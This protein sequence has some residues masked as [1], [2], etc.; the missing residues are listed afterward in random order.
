MKR[1]LTAMIAALLMVGLIASTAF[2]ATPS[3]LRIEL[4]NVVDPVNYGV[5]TA[6]VTG[7]ASVTLVVGITTGNWGSY[8]AVY[9]NAKAP[10]G[11]PLSKV[12]FGF[13]STGPSI[14]G[15]AP[16]LSIPIDT[17][18]DSGWDIFAFLD[19]ANCGSGL[20]STTIA[21]CPVFTSLGNYAN[22]DALV[23]ANSTW[24]MASDTMPFAIADQPGTYAL[25][26]ID[27]N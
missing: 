23:L 22:W 18:G 3:R 9:V 26:N 6:T 2:A 14:A 7:A 13:A 4:G 21:T 27:L 19:V 24:K 16:R 1:T 10:Y 5:A 11:K 20:V 17:N 8:A 12:D 15:G 25:W